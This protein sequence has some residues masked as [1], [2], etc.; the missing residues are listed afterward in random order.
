MSQEAATVPVDITLPSTTF[1][2]NGILA[3]GPSLVV[4]AAA[5]IL[6]D[7][8]Y[9]ISTPTSVPTHS[10]TGG[11]GVEGLKDGLSRRMAA[12]ANL[13]ARLEAEKC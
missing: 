5:V 8:R 11:S 2:G 13:Q 10:V 4:T 1:D 7:C 6:N 3:P 9:R 12:E